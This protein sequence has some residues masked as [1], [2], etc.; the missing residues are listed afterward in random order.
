ML[1]LQSL[2]LLELLLQKNRLGT[3]TFKQI[4]A[5]KNGSIATFFNP[6]QIES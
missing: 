4:A 3:A 1:P 5:A 2:K 6:Q